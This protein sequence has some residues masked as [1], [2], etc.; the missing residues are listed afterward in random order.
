MRND[1]PFLLKEKWT[2][3]ITTKQDRHPNCGTIE[4]MNKMKGKSQYRFITPRESL[5]LMGFDKSDY[6]KINNAGVKKN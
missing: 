5:M 3:T 1:N 6:D 4:Y 2:R